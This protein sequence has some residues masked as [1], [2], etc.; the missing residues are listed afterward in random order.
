VIEL[1]TDATANGLK[2]SIAMEEMGLQYNVHRIFLGGDQ[3]TPQFT[4]M[5]PNNK[6]PVI[7]DDGF[8]LSESGAILV[9]LAEKSGKLLPKDPKARAKVIEMVMF[10]VASV[11]PMLGQLIVFRGPWQNKFPE[12]TNRYA[13]EAARI[14]KVLNAR[15]EGKKYMAGDEFTIADIAVFPWI[16]LVTKLPFTAD[17]PVDQNANLKSWLERI[18]ERPAVQKGL[19]IPEPFPQEQQ[20]PAFIKATV[21]LGDL[22]AA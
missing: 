4:K 22:H 6:I 10:Q 8:V 20:F 12:V 18:R 5:N 7:D 19:T 21:G 9:Y 11:G 16:N 15:L 1:Y 14:F 17:L 2:I 13:V 3:M